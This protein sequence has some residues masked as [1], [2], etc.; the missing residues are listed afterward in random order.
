[1][2]NEAQIPDKLTERQDD[3]RS[4]NLD[5]ITSAPVTSVAEL[6][7]LSEELIQPAGMPGWAFRGQSQPFGTLVP[8]FQRQFSRRSRGAAEI[9]E[10]RLLKAFR[11]HYVELPDRS[12]DMPDPVE[13]DD[14]RAL[15]CLSVMQHYDIPTRL[16][17]WTANFWTAVLLRLRKRSWNSGRAVV[18]RALDV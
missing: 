9:I 7:D 11:E 17:D 15:R 3:V 6:I 5:E 13:I 18:L 1:M 2:N 10:Q 4:F 14:N 12:P 8:S 16:L